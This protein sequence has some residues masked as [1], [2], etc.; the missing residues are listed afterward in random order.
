M[1]M[2]ILKVRSD[3]LG[4][5]AKTTFGGGGL[6]LRGGF[7]LFLDLDG[8]H[9]NVSFVFF[10]LNVCF[11]YVCYISQLKNEETNQIIAPSGCT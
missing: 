8:G 11:M 3:Y 2:V 6:L 5:G 9:M 4:A 7:V 1:G 10:K